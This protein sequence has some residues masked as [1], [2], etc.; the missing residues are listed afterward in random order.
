MSIAKSRRTSAL[1]CDLLG[2]FCGREPVGV[3]GVDGDVET[4]G[5][6]IAEHFKRGFKSIKG[7]FVD[8]SGHLEEHPRAVASLIATIPVILPVENGD[9]SGLQDVKEAA[10]K[11]GQ[12][13]DDGQA[14]SS[15][16]SLT[17]KSEHSHLSSENNFWF[18][19]SERLKSDDPVL[20]QQYSRII[21]Q[22]GGK[23]DENSIEEI[24]IS[25]AKTATLLEV[26]ENSLKAMNSPSGRADKVL[27]KTIKIVGLA[28]DFVGSIVS[29]EPH[30]AVAWAG[31]CLFLPVRSSNLISNGSRAFLHL[32]T[33]ILKFQAEVVC[34][35][36]R[37]KVGA[38]FRKVFKTEQWEMM[39]QE[40][41]CKEEQCWSLAQAIDND[42]C[43]KFTE[44]L[45]MKLTELYDI[46]YELLEATKETRQAVNKLERTFE[47][48]ERSKEETECLQVFRS[49]NLYEL[50]QRRNPD[51]VPG[52]CEWLLKSHQFTDW[53]DKK[54]TGLLWISADPGCGKSVLSK[55][56]YQERL[57]SHSPDT[58]I[59]YFF[60][61]DLSPEQCSVTKAVAALLHQIFLAKGSLLKYAM[62]KWKTNGSELCNLHDSMW[63]ILE[64]IAA[65]KNAGDI[66]CI[67]DAFDECESKHGIGHLFIERMHKLVLKPE[68]YVKFVVTSRPYIQI[69]RMFKKLDHEFPVIH[70]AGEMES[71]NISQEINLVIKHEVSRLEVDETVKGHIENR[72][73]E[74]KH[75][76]YLWLYLIMDVIRQRI[77]SSGNA[78][79]IDESLQTLPETVEKVYEEIL[80]KSPYRSETEKLLHII[81]G[82]ERPLSTDE[83]NVAM[84][85]ELRY[86]GTQ[87]FNDIP[88]EKRELY[89]GMLRN[90]CGLFVQIV[91]SKVYLIHQ[92]AKEFLVATG[93][94]PKMPDTWR[95]CLEPEETQKFLAQVCI[96]YLYLKDFNTWETFCGSPY[97]RSILKIIYMP[98]KREL[99]TLLEYSATNWVTH[100]SSVRRTTWL[101]INRRLFRGYNRFPFKA[102]THLAGPLLEDLTPLMIFSVYNLY[103]AAKY[104]ISASYFRKQDLNLCTYENLSAL[105]LAVMHRNFDMVKLLVQNG[106]D[107]NSPWNVGRTRPL[108]R[109]ACLGHLDITLF[110]LDNN[111]HD[112]IKDSALG[113]AISHKESKIAD[114]LLKRMRLPPEKGYLEEVLLLAVRYNHTYVD[115][116]LS[117]GADPCYPVLGQLL[118]SQS[119]LGATVG[120]RSGVDSGPMGVIFKKLLQNTGI[121]SARVITEFLMGAASSPKDIQITDYADLTRLFLEHPRESGVTFQ[122]AQ[123]P[124][125]ICALYAN[126]EILQIL[127]DTFDDSSRHRA[128]IRYYNKKDVQPWDCISR[129]LW[130]WGGHD[131]RDYWDYSSFGLSLPAPLYAGIMSR[132]LNVVLLLMDYGADINMTTKLGTPLFYAA[133][134]SVNKIVEFLISKGAQ[135]MPYDSEGNEE[136]SPLVIAASKGNIEI[137]KMLLEF[138]AEVDHGSAWTY[139]I[140]ASESGNRF[141]PSAI[142]AAE[143]EGHEEVATLLREH[144]ARNSVPFVGVPEDGMKL[145]RVEELEDDVAG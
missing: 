59:C 72:L 62:A 58:V 69:E 51:R 133:A 28:K 107:V 81:V 124:I 125:V 11:Q 55:A 43:S 129:S 64:D 98:K 25:L 41:L 142:E 31:V 113:I 1:R 22:E 38:Y 77:E 101:R 60:F 88:L 3:R 8:R 13:S 103:A 84:N 12:I 90:L 26:C 4:A 111:A 74:M 87:G 75:R 92:T 134:L 73:Q 70:M 141:Y 80:N 63:D 145:G 89:P 143:M 47:Q 135:V 86:D 24:S 109:A 127:L 94:D 37:S 32:Y 33:K 23:S 93:S 57:V 126:L 68:C 71:E 10:R 118:I 106:A 85:I 34:Q 120:Y 18:Q 45:A 48:H 131:G 130:V 114:L 76:T 20:Y 132:N 52:T 27:E 30:A 50:Q 121:L 144:K 67:I 16:A 40:V 110:L 83:I 140:L 96:S 138:G 82:A 100:Y 7:S 36:G 104:M 112:V 54:R 53:R 2:A 61:K 123:S 108:Y 17:T 42:R 95:H 49:A 115:I 99:S 56:L 14:G 116:L 137:V 15:I 78:R 66:V 39:H 105:Y 5:M 117:Y 9:R 79:K 91:D 122:K 119:A 29:V 136:P 21:Q 44:E 35:L 102:E 128:I 6:P 97:D 139:S 19:A 46:G 65:D